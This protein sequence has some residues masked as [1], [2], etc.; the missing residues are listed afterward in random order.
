MADLPPADRV[1]AVRRENADVAD[2]VIAALRSAGVENVF[3]CPGSRSTPL[4]FALDRHGIRTHVMIDERVA[5]FAA[6][7]AAH[8]GRP[9]AI[10]TTSG[11]AVANLL[12]AACEADA[13][14]L[15]WIAVTADRPRAMINTGAN[16]TL[17]QPPLLRGPARRV[18]DLPAATDDG[19]LSR[20]QRVTS[21]DDTMAYVDG[22]YRGP[23]HIDVRFSKPLEPPVDHVI[24]SL[25]HELRSARS[26]TR[27][28]AVI[29]HQLGYTSVQRLI[30]DLRPARRG[31][32]V[33]GSLARSD[34]AAAQQIVRMLGWPAI[35]DVTSGLRRSGLPTIAT[36]AV[37]VATVAAALVPDVV[38]Q[39]GGT[40]TEEVVQ[41]WL[42]S[43]PRNTTRVLQLRSGQSVRDP[44]AR[45]DL[46]TIAPPATWSALLSPIHQPSA[47]LPLAM[48][49]RTATST[50]IEQT[51][52]TSS[53]NA[54]AEPSVARA[55]LSSVRAGEVL[56]IGNSM[57]VRDADRYADL[58][59]LE[60]VAD[61]PTGIDVVT[62]R[63]VSGID[64]TIATAL[65]ACLTSQRPTTAFV[66][67]LAALHDLG[68][69]AAT[70]Q[71][72]APVRIVVVNNAG[73]G[74]FSFLPVAGANS[75]VVERY[76]GT[77]H[78]FSLATIAAGMG[79]RTLRIND[80]VSLRAAL[81][82]AP[83]GPEL[84]EITTSRADNVVVHQRLDAAIAAACEQA[85][86]TAT[87]PSEAGAP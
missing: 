75:D 70:Q 29:V 60:T 2:D 42:A 69:I 39:L 65:G 26:H 74:I 41:R 5:G 24:T 32:V 33:V 14:E 66:G 53:M 31:L 9:A 12:P 77:P 23:I 62:N 73:G 58:A 78:T 11:T 54:I 35:V 56:L 18:L 16:Q 10:V 76:F 46:V 67:D 55:V 79:L 86:A 4:V 51:L 8:V 80:E 25:R 61:D 64:G 43:L 44:E 83:T 1:E 13:A 20:S 63:G 19:A 81:S 7:G 85:L 57:P 30:D 84:I 17:D 48:A 36:V 27:E 71:A 68:G 47:L 49:L 3:V 50:A 22:T 37:R 52:A 45:V 72:G 6:V 15:P 59:D 40:M 34:R 28:A 82:A 38:L 87:T 21:L